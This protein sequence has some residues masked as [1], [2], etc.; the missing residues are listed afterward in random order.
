M[1]TFNQIKSLIGFCQTDE[2]FL[3]YLQKLQGVGVIQV[4]DGDIDAE[5]KTLSDD[6]YSRLADVYGVSSGDEPAPAVT[7]Q[8]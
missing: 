4:V 2:F 5:N 3:E 8:E 6:F 7:I 1:K